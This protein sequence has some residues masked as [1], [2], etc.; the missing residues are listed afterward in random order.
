[1]S[2]ESKSDKCNRC[3]N[4]DICTRYQE[5]TTAL[6]FRYGDCSVFDDEREYTCYNCNEK[7]ICSFAFDPYNKDGDCLKQK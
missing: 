7:E 5:G 2:T 1:M 4:K 3:L 6:L